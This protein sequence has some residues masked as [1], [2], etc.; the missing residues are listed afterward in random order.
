MP[1]IAG[2][3]SGLTGRSGFST[4]SGRFLHHSLGLAPGLQQHIDEVGVVI[5]VAGLHPVVKIEAAVLVM[6]MVDA[7]RDD[8][9]LEVE[10]PGRIAHALLGFRIQGHASL[11]AGS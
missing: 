2:G 9:I 3:H 10:Q 8:H 11:D 6:L 1:T 5:I 4:V 7:G